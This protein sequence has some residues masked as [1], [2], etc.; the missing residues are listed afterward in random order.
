[1]RALGD[2]PGAR[3]FL[4]SL[5]YFFKLDPSTIGFWVEPSAPL[6]RHCLDIGVHQTY[7]VRLDRR[8]ES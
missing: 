8:S 3:V 6:M 7:H 4:L 2:F 5:Q 1:L